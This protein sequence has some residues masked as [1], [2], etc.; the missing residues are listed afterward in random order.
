VQRGIAR[1]SSTCDRCYSSR[2]RWL[3]RRLPSSLPRAPLNVPIHT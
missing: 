1:G 2:R 3:R